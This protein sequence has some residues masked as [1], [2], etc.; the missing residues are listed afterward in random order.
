M[1]KLGMMLLALWLGASPVYAQQVQQQGK[2]FIEVTTSKKSKETKTEYLYTNSKGKVYP[3]YLSS[4]GKA[5]IKRVS[6][7]SGKEYKRYLPE[8]GKKINPQAYKENK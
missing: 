2:N 4:T 8:V 1:E 5:F 6:K 7:K 3:I